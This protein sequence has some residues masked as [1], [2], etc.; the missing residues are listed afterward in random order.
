M[1]VTD[2]KGGAVEV[3]GVITERTQDPEPLTDPTVT[4]PDRVTWLNALL[5]RGDVRARETV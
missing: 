3:E 2:A 5:C 1:A 4:R